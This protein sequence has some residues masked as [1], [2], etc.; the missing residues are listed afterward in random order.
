MIHTKIM[1]NV[2]LKGPV[3]SNVAAAEKVFAD[4]LAPEL[5]GVLSD[6]LLRFRRLDALSQMPSYVF[7]G[8]YC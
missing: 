7:R 5:G 3:A 4:V 8:R 6:T 2:F 1:F